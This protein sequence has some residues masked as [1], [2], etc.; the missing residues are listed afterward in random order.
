MASGY[1][2][3]FGAFPYAFRQSRSRLFKSYVVCSAL[4]VAFISLFIVIALIVLVGQTAAIQGGQLTLSRAFYIVV[5]LLVILP[6][7]APTLVVARRH[8]RGIES[9][10]RYE[11]ALAIAGYLF[12]LSLY[13]GAVASMPETFVLDGETVARP[14]PTG[15]FAPVISLLYAIPQAFSWSVPLVGAL[16]V[17]AAHK[18]F[19]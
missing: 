8:R 7:V 6:A 19:G 4:A 1:N 9:S 11:V 5:G 2:G 10:P 18:L 15:L 14:A 17:A 13:L 12:L 16:L 3:V